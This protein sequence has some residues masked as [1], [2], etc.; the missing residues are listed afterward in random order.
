VLWVRS[1]AN[2]G[3]LAEASRACAHGIQ[4]HPDSAELSYLRSVLMLQA[5]RPAD[6]MAAARRSLYLDRHFVVS[7]LAMA[8]ASVR[9]G[10]PARAARSL[11]TAARLLSSMAPDAVVPGS[12]GE[13]VNRLRQ[14]V[15]ARIALL[16]EAAA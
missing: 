2:Q 13:T 11:R 15:A 4:R 12:D 9:A 16:G 6:A 8:D 5:A 3:L 10:D 1:A 7:H 14:N